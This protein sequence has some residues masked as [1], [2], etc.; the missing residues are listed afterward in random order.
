M[1]SAPDPRWSSD[2]L[3]E[4]LFDRAPVALY[5]LDRELRYV[6]L[7]E[8]AAA[9][10]GLPVSAHLGRRMSDLLPQAASAL[11]PLVQRVIDTGEPIHSLELVAHHLGEPGR[12]VWCLGSAYPVRDGSGEI[13]GVGIVAIDITARKQ[14]EEALRDSEARF[15]EL[16]EN[17]PAVFWMAEFDPPRL[18]YLSSAYEK[19]WGRPAVEQYARTNAFVDAVHPEDRSRLRQAMARL[20]AE[21]Y[22]IEY[23]IVLPDARVRWIR[24]RAFS[25][26]AVAG[27][28][29]AAG[30]SVDVTEQRQ[31][32]EQLRHAQKMESLGRLAGGVAHDFNNLVT[33]IL[34]H[35][36]F[37]AESLPD[38]HPAGGELAGIQE[39][40]TRAAGVTRQLLSFARRQVLS[41]RIVDVN[42]LVRGLEGL[43]VR[44]IGEDV[45]LI[46]SLQP[47]PL[48]VRVD[49]GQ[50]EQVIVN[51]AVNA[52]DAMPAGGKL[53]LETQ[54]ATHAGSDLPL[55]HGE[56]VRI[57]V[58]DTGHGIAPDVRE[59]LFEPFFTTKAP[60]EGTG[61]GLA[62]SYGIVQ[63]CGG[64]IVVESRA[65]D[66]SHFDVYLPR[67]PESPVAAA[68]HGGDALPRG[69]ETIL[70]VEDE[71]S[72]RGVVARTLR[73]QGYEVMEA[74]DG[75][76]ALSLARRRPGPIHLLLSDVVMPQMGGVELAERLREERPDTRLML[77][78]G[79][80]ERA[81][82][83]APALPRGSAF[84]QKPFRRETLVR[85][86]RRA[87]DGDL[88]S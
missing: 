88:E 15:R 13:F 59:H 16:A 26:G 60:G 29:R 6:R 42:A 56:Y 27:V 20:P 38:D 7:N 76:E 52:R 83:G 54:A 41:P 67:A 11:E 55:Q 36:S 45:E 79:Y 50:L 21:G 72:V 46:T 51:L 31:L 8:V 58:S 32:E 86:V 2:S 12:T 57:R 10:N 73:E 65:G 40:A 66:G 75:R 71:P 9:L 85:E 18:V 34:G 47:E 1:T 80:H 19:V 78:S 5:F 4:A 63:Q 33:A 44:L 30:I 82:L 87:L 74:A 61:L 37:A 49:A 84:L 24:D 69:S 3:L 62:T 81:A 64:H 17:I 22:E 28:R 39:A 14:A 48:C 25:L 35:A 77:V 53:V 70:L 68:S 23:R 43:L